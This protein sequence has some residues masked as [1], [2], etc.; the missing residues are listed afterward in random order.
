MQDSFLPRYPLLRHRAAP[1]HGSF[2]N[3]GSL[4]G[5]ATPGS[6]PRTAPRAP[7]NRHGY[8]L[9]PQG[10][11][12]IPQDASDGGLHAITPAVPGA[13]E[14]VWKNSYGNADKEA[15]ALAAAAGLDFLGSFYDGDDDDL[16][17]GP[18]VGASDADVGEAEPPAQDAQAPPPSTFDEEASFPPQARRKIASQAAYIA[19]LEEQQL[20]LRE[21]IFLLEQQLAEAQQRR[22]ASPSGHSN[23]EGGSEDEHATSSSD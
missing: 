22:G 15:V 4:E 23:D 6:T 16:G 18:Q 13:G 11:F 2:W 5:S 21:R 20:T 10:S 3:K 17:V 9:V 8:L 7:D 1:H 14:A 12:H 19:Q